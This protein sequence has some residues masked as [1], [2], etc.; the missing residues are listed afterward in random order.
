MIK[1]R[2]GKRKNVSWPRGNSTPEEGHLDNNSHFTVWV[3]S[4]HDGKWHSPK[5]ISGLDRTTTT[6]EHIRVL[7]GDRHCW[8]VCE[9]NRSGKKS[10]RVPDVESEI[11]S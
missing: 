6:R 2:V 9:L 4:V 5:D 8:R 10:S 7:I 1:R 3:L 11:S